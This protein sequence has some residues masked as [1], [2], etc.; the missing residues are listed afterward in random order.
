VMRGKRKRNTV[1]ANSN[2]C[3]TLPFLTKDIG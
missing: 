2:K 3:L 1:A